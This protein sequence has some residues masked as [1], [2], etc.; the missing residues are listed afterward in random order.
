MGW[1]RLSVAS[2]EALS[3]AYQ[4]PRAID[5]AGNNNGFVCGQARPDSVRDAYCRS[6]LSGPCIL[7]AQGLPIYLWQDDDNPAGD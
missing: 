1:E 6:G 3:V 5:E 4:R 2:M 7:Q